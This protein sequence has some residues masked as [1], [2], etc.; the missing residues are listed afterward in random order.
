MHPPPPAYA[1]N[2]PSDPQRLVIGV[3]ALGSARTPHV[4]APAQEFLDLALVAAVLVDP[5]SPIH[6]QVVPEFRH[7]LARGVAVAEP[8]LWSRRLSTPRP[9]RRLSISLGIRKP[10]L[11]SGPARRPVP[12]G[13]STGAGRFESSEIASLRARTPSP[14]TL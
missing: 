7:G 8:R 11:R 10:R 12:H 6:A 2:A 13:G 4:R 14:A 9:Y 5:A 1:A 3:D